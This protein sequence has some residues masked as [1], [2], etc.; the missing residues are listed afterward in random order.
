MISTFTDG[1]LIYLTYLFVKVVCSI[2]CLGIIHLLGYKIHINFKKSKMFVYMQLPSLLVFKLKFMVNIMRSVI[3]FL[4]M[5]TILVGC[6]KDE[7]ES[8]DCTLTRY[9]FQQYRLPY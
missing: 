5:V 9:L 2:C 6:G 4:M 1:P 3:S 7:P 8:V